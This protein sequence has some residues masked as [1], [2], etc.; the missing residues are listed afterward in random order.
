[1]Q[2]SSASTSNSYVYKIFSVTVRPY[3]VLV[4]W[5]YVVNATTSKEAAQTNK[6]DSTII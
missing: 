4:G 1:M 3:N 2:S 5:S 6:Y